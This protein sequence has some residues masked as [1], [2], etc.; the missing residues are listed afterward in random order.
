MGQEGRGEGSDVN[1]GSHLVRDALTD[2]FDRAIIVTNDTD[3]IE[4]IRI[5]RE[6]ANKSV[7]LLSTV[8]GEIQSNGRWRGASEKLVAAADFT[9]YIHNKHLA[10]SQFPQVIGQAIR[11]ATWA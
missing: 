1:L 7:G 3:L 8:V 4:P 5:A 9:L 2:A 6:E 11:P 10:Q